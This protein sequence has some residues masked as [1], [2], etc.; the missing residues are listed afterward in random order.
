MSADV[1]PRHAVDRSRVLLL[2]A[3]GGVGVLAGYSPRAA[4]AGAAVAA[5]SAL[6]F[7]YAE[8]LP[9]MFLTALGGLLVVYLVLGKGGAYLNVGGVFI[10]E[11]VLAFGIVTVLASGALPLAVRNG[12]GWWVIAFGVCGALQT[13][14]YLAIYGQNALRDAVVW[15][16]GAFALLTAACLTRTGW[17]ARTVAAYGRVL[18]WFPFWVPPLW[19][20]FTYGGAVAPKVPG[21]GGDIPLIF[22]KSGDPAFHL[23]GIAAFVMLGLHERSGAAPSPASRHRERWRRAVSCGGRPGWWPSPSQPRPVGPRSWRCSSR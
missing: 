17:L 6:A 9:R 8:R 12:L 15:G 3:A 19:A 11:G 16:Y 7:A 14:P 13:I 4:V 10:G 1:L 20:I 18:A 2:L 23:T 21:T 5:V 22:F